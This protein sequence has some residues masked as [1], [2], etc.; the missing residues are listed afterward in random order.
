VLI[1]VVSE[2]ALTTLVAGVGGDVVVVSFFCFRT[3]ETRE[4]AVW[5][6]AALVAVQE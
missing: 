1:V 3:T 6:P 5:V 2:L 4:E